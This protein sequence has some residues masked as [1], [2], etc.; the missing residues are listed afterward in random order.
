MIFYHNFAGYLTT[1][2]CTFSRCLRKGEMIFMRFYFLPFHC[3]SEPTSLETELICVWMTRLR[4]KLSETFTFKEQIL[5]SIRS[6]KKNCVHPYVYY[7]MFHCGKKILSIF[8]G[9]TLSDLSLQFM[10]KNYS[11]CSA[12]SFFQSM[13]CIACT[14]SSQ[15]LFFVAVQLVERFFGKCFKKSYF[16]DHLWKGWNVQSMKAHFNQR[17][18]R[19]FYNL[20][21]FYVLHASC[22]EFWIMTMVYLTKTNDNHNKKSRDKGN[23]TLIFLV[24]RWRNRKR[25]YLPPTVL[26]NE[27]LCSTPHASH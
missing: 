24:S 6:V 3:D 2:P 10:Y 18:Y 5:F 11:F 8:F 4:K 20:I 16:T 12:L 1:H 17:F 26:P 7:V 25:E 21:F 27:N 22:L 9:L 19:L 15:Y 14:N 23:H 13:H